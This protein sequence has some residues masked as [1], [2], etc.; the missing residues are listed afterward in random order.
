M[1]ESLSF[2]LVVIGGG[3]AGYVG[4]IRAAQLGLKVA[5][6]ERDRLGG[7]CLNWGCI[8]TKALIA[9]AELYHKL[10][11]EAAAWGIQ[12][13]NIRHDWT[14]VIGRS[15]DVAGKLN[16]GIGA[17]FKKHKIPSFEGNAKITQAPVPFKPGAGAKPGVVEVRNAKGELTQTISAGRILIATGASPRPLPMPGAGFDGEKV[18][19][20]KEAMTLTTQPKT[21]L[22]IGAGAI[23]MEFAYIYNAFGTKVTVIE[24]LDRLLP[25]EDE[26]AS[27]LVGKLFRK[28]GI[29]T[30]TGHKT[31]AV[32]KTAD[33][34]ELTVA[35]TSNEKETSILKGDKVL[36]AV[37]VKGNITSLWDEKINIEVFKEHIKVDRK[38]YQTSVPG[39]Y[40]IGDVNGPPWLA[41]V[42][43]EEAVNC[44]EEIAGVHSHA[45]DYDAIPGCTYCIPQVA[46]M[47][48][49]EQALKAKGLKVG[50]D[51]TVGKF[52][53]AGS[54][55]AQALST[56]RV[57]EGFVKIIG[58]KKTGEIMGVHMVGDGV[59]ELLA[60]MGLAK[61]L[62]ATVEEV[63]ATMHSHPTLSE[64]VHEA[65]L[66]T[67]GR[68]LHF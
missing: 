1:S 11:H 59:T 57:V 28:Q 50:V 51:Y 58:D 3:P 20:S 41:H 34:V 49:T 68:M 52:P 32:K 35:P 25:N 38:E 39:I 63:I 23:G 55:K 7:T 19:S 43:M 33:G 24:M 17:L 8:P 61:R 62:E 53:F 67:Q 6:I 56:E 40:A 66:G 42:A 4:A 5:C 26:E 46:S 44:V 18:I 29:E 64:A 21:L 16:K 22:I 15:R 27:A 48:F 2:D 47:G 9:N 10:T 12:A 13:D 65:A 30:L 60:E 54:G 37:G 36:V 31:L 14:K 45:I